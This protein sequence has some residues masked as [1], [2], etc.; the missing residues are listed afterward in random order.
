MSREA[1]SDLSVFGVIS[2]GISGSKHAPVFALIPYTHVGVEFPVGAGKELALNR[3]EDV[4]GGSLGAYQRF[5]RLPP[6]LWT[7]QR[8]TYGQLRR[9]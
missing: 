4:P 7:D 9:L 3:N 8:M 6:S 2:A 5:A 1:P